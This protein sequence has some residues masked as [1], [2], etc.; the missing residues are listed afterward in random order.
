[1]R[2]PLLIL[3]IIFVSIFTIW[4]FIHQDKRSILTI[5]NEVVSERKE[6][7][8]LEANEDFFLIR[9]YPDAYIDPRAYDAG[10]KD[11]IA[12]KNTAR[13]EQLWSL[14]GPGNIGGRINCMA[15]E[16]GNENVIYAGNASGGIFKTTDGGITWLPIFDAQ[17]YL[18]IGAITID[19]NNHQTIWVGT[20]DLN[21]SGYPF[22]GDGVYKSVDGGAT[23]VHMGLTE[24][25]IVS[26][27]LVDPSNSNTIYAS[28]MGIPFFESSNRGLYKSLDGGISW[29]QILFVD[30]DAGIIDM[31]M[32]PLNAQI[33]YAS[34]WNRIRSNQLSI[35]Y[36][37]DA[38]IYKTTDGGITWSTLTNGLPTFNTGRIGLAISKQ[39]SSKLYALVVDTTHFVQ[40]IYKTLDGG[41]SW[42]NVTGNF[43]NETYG[44]QG[45]YF[46]KIYVNPQNDDEIYVPG[47]DLQRAM[48]GGTYWNQ[49]TPPWWTYEVH[50]DGHYMDFV[51]GST[52]FYCTDGGM[53]KTTDD[54][55]SWT[56]A[57]NIPNTQFY[58]VAYNPFQPADVF[59]GAQDN[60]TTGGNSSF[61]DYWSRIYGGDGFK[62][63]FDPINNN[64]F[65][66]E[67]QNGGLAYTANGG[68][69]YFDFTNGID[70]SDRRSWDMPY[71]MSPQ[72]H[73]RFFCG[74]YR[75][76]E[77]IGAPGGYW[78]AISTDLTD[79]IIYEDRFHVITT[80]SQSSLNE[81]F[82][83]AGTSDGNVWSSTIGGIWNNVTSALPDRYVTSIAASP[84]DATTVYVTHSGYKYNDFI[85][86]VHKSTDN[87]QTWT[88]I[89][90][91]LPQMGVND[92]LI[93]PGAEYRLIV[94]T[95]AGVYYTNNGGLN[96]NRLGSNMPMMAVYDI[97]LNPAFNTLIA[98]TFARGIWTIGLNDIT[99]VQEVFNYG[100]GILSL[101]PNPVKDAL[102]FTLDDV[103]VIEATVTN[104]SGQIVYS[105]KITSAGSE[106]SLSVESLPDGMYLV[107]AKAGEKRWV[108]KFVKFN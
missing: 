63:I 48:N 5:N 43:S 62:P 36:G 40:G 24:E 26:K 46:G 77:M 58:H 3:S 12:R 98:G 21:I 90:G 80:I 69:D 29:Q 1:M 2:K 47:V 66:V 31:V 39:N 49:A 108:E 17:P 20:G 60:G 33:I 14:E 99:G 37:P 25:S 107:E 84:S 23:W 76:Y 103:K 94:A 93:M 38:H 83:Y 86:H 35:V 87:G 100:D 30:E 95:D 102:H 16:S 68:F 96:W 81:N 44:G 65:Y 45:W 71:I 70:E 55:N 78:S 89:S 41:A 64:L 4:N 57:E 92:I 54:C 56:D 53:Y 13:D 28:T 8:N 11:A 101:Y 73:T 51:N 61:I 106:F 75:I 72:D 82:L 50:A 59:G 7:K 10:M 27:I 79:G 22:I 6:E 52:F 15:I 91:D 88:D 18:A 104:S 19:P 85:P 67:T 97:E 74:T 34:S 105:S 9:S 32:D 42:S